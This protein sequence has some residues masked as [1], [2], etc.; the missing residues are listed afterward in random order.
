MSEQRPVSNR[1]E[2]SAGHARPG[3]VIKN[4]TQCAQSG[5]AVR[6]RPCSRLGGPYRVELKAW[7]RAWA[8]T[9]RAD[10]GPATTRLAFCATRTTVSA[11]DAS[12]PRRASLETARPRVCRPLQP[13]PARFG[14]DCAPRRGSATAAE[15]AGEGHAGSAVRE[16]AAR[17][18][19]GSAQQGD[20]IGSLRRAHRQAMCVATLCATACEPLLDQHV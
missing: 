19:E 5:G 17:A 13:L 16:A 20:R 2:E 6:G 10:A 3:R 4:E 9:H 14:K 15:S 7:E 18:R 8:F 11:E 12:T 1:T